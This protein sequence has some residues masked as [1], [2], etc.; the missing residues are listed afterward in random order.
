MPILAP[1]S[2]AAL[3]AAYREHY[4]KVRRYLR[5][6]LRDKERA[7]DLAAETFILLAR[8]L[9]E[10]V[11]PL[12]YEAYSMELARGQLRDER[13][14]LARSREVLTDAEALGNVRSLPPLSIE[15]VE[16]Q[17]DL[18]RA[19]R[20]LPPTKRDTFILIE[21][22]G[23]TTRASAAVLGTSQP[24][25]VRRRHQALALVRSAL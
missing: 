4:P 22:R 10:G 13:K 17:V 6:A 14:R 8:K 3:D 21:L 12:D 20:A 11:L 18:D 15:D 16:F 7:D 19:V 9:A 1:D 23:L 2:Q 25:E 24:T 5:S